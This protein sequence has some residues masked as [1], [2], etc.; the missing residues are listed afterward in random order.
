MGS[1]FDILLRQKPVRI[2]QQQRRNRVVEYFV[3]LFHPSP[4]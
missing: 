2:S 3:D 1:L 4:L